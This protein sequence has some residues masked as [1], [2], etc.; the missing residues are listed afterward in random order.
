M[1]PIIPIKFFLNLAIGLHKLLILL[2]QHKSFGNK[3]EIIFRVLFLHFRDIDRE[4]IFPCKLITQREMVDFLSI[5]Q[6]LVK[7]SFAGGVGPQ[8]VPVMPIG[9]HQPIQ[10]QNKF[11]QFALTFQHFVETQRGLRLLVPLHR[12]VSLLVT[13]ALNPFNQR[14][15]YFDLATC[16]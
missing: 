6:A 9:A 7:I 15:V 13:D 8:H 3:V 1:S 16:F 5:G 4:S 10:F 12:E 2:W 11:D 14:F